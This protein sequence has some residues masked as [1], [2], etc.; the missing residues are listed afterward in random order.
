MTTTV[1]LHGIALMRQPEQLAERRPAAAASRAPAPAA[2]E[3]WTLCT[4]A[5]S[6]RSDSRT[7]VVG[8]TNRSRPTPTIN[9]SSTA[10][11]SGSRMRNVVPLPRL[12]RDLDSAAQRVDVAAHDVHADAASGDLGD[13]VGG[14]EPGLEDQHVDLVGRRRA[15]PAQSARARSPCALIFSVSRPFPS[16]AISMTMWPPW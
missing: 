10:S 2:A 16:S 4:C 11:V 14:R 12:G 9:P 15:R 6:G 3:P 5:G 8:I 13:L 1:A 7:A